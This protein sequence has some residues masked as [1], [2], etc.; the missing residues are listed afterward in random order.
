MED[1]INAIDEVTLEDVN[2]YCS[3]FFDIDKLAWSFVIPKN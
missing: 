3:E 2:K 1:I